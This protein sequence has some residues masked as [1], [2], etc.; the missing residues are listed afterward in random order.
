MSSDPAVATVDSSGVV[1]GVSAGV[2]TITA[3]DTT[4]PDLFGHSYVTVKPSSPSPFAYIT[5]WGSNTVS[6]I[7]TATNTVTATVPVG[8]EPEG[9]AVIPADRRYT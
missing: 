8:T 7:N 6:V 1:T 5:N 2:A 4:N 9:V 3:Q